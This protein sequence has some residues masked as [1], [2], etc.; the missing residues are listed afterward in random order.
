MYVGRDCLLVVS[1]DWGTSTCLE[2]HVFGPSVGHMHAAAVRSDP[3]HVPDMFF[4]P[5]I[6]LFY[7]FK[8]LSQS[9]LAIFSLLALQHEIVLKYVISEDVKIPENV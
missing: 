8:L 7:Y 2:K 3:L 4:N 1:V 5:Q 6:Q 9:S